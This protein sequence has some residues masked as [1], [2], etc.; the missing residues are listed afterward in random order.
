MTLHHGNR[1]RKT[2]GGSRGFA[3]SRPPKELGWTTATL[4]RARFESAPTKSAWA[5]TARRATPC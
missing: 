2:S 3:S 1:I 5:A 4:P